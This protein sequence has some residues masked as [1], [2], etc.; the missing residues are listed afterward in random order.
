M[1]EIDAIARKKGKWYRT[2]DK[3]IEELD[4]T[5]EEVGR[6]DRSTLKSC[7]KLYDNKLWEQ[8][9][10]EK[11]VMRFYAKE[12]KVIGYKFCYNNSFSSKIYARARLNALQLEEHKGRGRQGHDTKCRLCQE[13]IEDI[14]HFTI[15]CKKLESKRNDEIID[16]NIKDPEERMRALLFRNK[17]YL[18]VGKMLRD[19]WDLRNR[20]IKQKEIERTNTQN[21][22]AYL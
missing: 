14:T 9:L 1:C 21:R 3:Y 19:L 15:K 17:D 6:M 4:L 16:K 2:V 22:K 13:E 20:L 10:Q 8:G 7:I 18:S 11:K 12:K 5:W